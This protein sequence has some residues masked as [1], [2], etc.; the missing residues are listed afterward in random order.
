MQ[1]K[2]DLSSLIITRKPV[3]LALSQLFIVSE[4]QDSPEAIA[5][6][7]AAS[8][9]TMDEIYFILRYELT[10][11]LRAN[12]SIFAW[13]GDAFDEAWLVKKL[14]PRINR[15]PWFS[16]GLPKTI[17]ADWQQVQRYVAIYRQKN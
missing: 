11:V 4:Y 16:F 14:T 17:H 6:T 5:H 1:N 9:Y 13:P 2:T 12:L 10:P 15:K 7:L 8:A 3:W